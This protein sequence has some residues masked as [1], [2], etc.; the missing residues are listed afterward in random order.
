MNNQQFIAKVSPSQRGRTRPQVPDLL[1]AG[2]FAPPLH[3]HVKIFC[4]RFRRIGAEGHNRKVYKA[5]R[6]WSFQK[7]HMV[8]LALEVSAL[9]PNGESKS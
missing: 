9:L 1:G 7:Y 5:R 2:S 4:I 6:S 8:N 3:F